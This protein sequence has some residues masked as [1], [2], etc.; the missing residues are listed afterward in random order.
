MG[1]ESYSTTPASNNSAPPNGAPEGWA[2]SSVNDWGRQFMAD[3]R[4]QWQHAEWFNWGDTATYA[5]ATSFTI[6]S[7]VTSR[8]TVG[9]RIWVNGATPGDIYGTIISSSYAAPDTTVTIVFDSGSMSNEALTVYLSSTDPTNNSLSNAIGIPQLKVKTANES[10]TSSTT[11]QDD[12]HL[13]GFNLIAGKWYEVSGMLFVDG[14][15]IPGMD[16]NF[17]FTNAVQDRKFQY[18]KG[19]AIPDGSIGQASSG[20][21]LS[22]VVEYNSGL[23]LSESFT[24]SSTLKI[25][26]I[27]LRGVFLSNAT[28]G[29]TMKLQWAQS[30][31]SATATTLYKGSFIK[32]VQLN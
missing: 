6:A 3:V 10:V 21:D 15:N 27:D 8:Y 7:D 5:S 29:G 20:S 18:F 31:S 14:S 4:T 32:L 22:N 16:F 1:I 25:K 9:R 24:E 30:T 17:I 19:F 11:L 12:D 28:T 2:P 26:P 13:T 23:N